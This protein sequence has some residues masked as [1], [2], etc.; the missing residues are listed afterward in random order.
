MS[1]KRPAGSVLPATCHGAASETEEQLSFPS[2]TVRVEDTVYPR[3]QDNPVE[4][5]PIP[6]CSTTQHE[7]LRANITQLPQS[8]KNLHLTPIA[9]S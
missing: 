8:K 7:E 3:R 9:A 5:T 2:V 4:K 1:K 6:F